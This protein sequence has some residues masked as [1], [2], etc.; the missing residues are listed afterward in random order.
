[1]HV[2]L[3]LKMVVSGN[4]YINLPIFVFLFF[5]WLQSI[6]NSF[7]GVGWVGWLHVRSAVQ[8]SAARHMYV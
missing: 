2:C 8:C 6:P 1:M 3:V 7:R 4:K 5:G